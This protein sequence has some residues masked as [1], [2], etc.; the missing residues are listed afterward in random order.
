VLF[1]HAIRCEFTDRNPISGPNR[2]AGVRQSSRRQNIPDI[3]E[4]SEMQDILA[5]Q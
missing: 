2:G 3:L 1:N 4:A 5:V